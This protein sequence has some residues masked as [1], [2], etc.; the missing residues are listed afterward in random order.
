MSRA[1][2]RAQTWRS[3]LTAGAC[4]V[5]SAVGG[6]AGG[7]GEATYVDDYGYGVYYGSAWEAGWYGGGPVY[8]GPPA[9]PPPGAIGGR[10]PGSAGGAPPHV[11]NLPSRPL[12]A[13]RPTGGGGGRRR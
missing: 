1:N 3:A 4:V 6:C 13:A 2:V 11:S 5:A 7:S 12:P 9:Y 10:P 8:V